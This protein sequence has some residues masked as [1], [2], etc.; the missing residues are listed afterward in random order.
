MKKKVFIVGIV[1]VGIVSFISGV[2][3]LLNTMFNG[4]NKL[5]LNQT[6]TKFMIN[7]TAVFAFV[8]EKD[9]YYSHYSYDSANEE[10][11]DYDLIIKDA[12][13]EEID[14]SLYAADGYPNG[15]AYLKANKTYYYIFETECSEIFKVSIKLTECDSKIIEDNQKVLI[16]KNSVL[17]YESDVEGVKNIKIVGDQNFN[18]EI[19]NSDEISYDN[20]KKEGIISFS[21]HKDEKYEIMI[22]DIKNET[23]V[24]IYGN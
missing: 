16:N 11:I 2:I 24:I 19:D 22:H 12:E 23:E 20:F 10:T 9:G 6:K 18:I 7:K 3:L 21:V 1:V 5:E 13:G 4:D 15:Y 14:Y 17:L 8:P